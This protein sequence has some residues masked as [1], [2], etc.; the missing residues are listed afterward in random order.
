[1]KNLILCCLFIFLAG[2]PVSTVNASGLETM[3]FIENDESYFLFE[4]EQPI[5]GEIVDESS[6]ISIN[7]DT[8]TVTL[9]YEEKGEVTPPASIDVTRVVNGVTYQGTAYLKTYR[10]FDGVTTATYKGTLYR[11]ETTSTS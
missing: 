1:M 10:Y 4:S 11:V 9:T 8:M 3:A 7:G 6:Q 5:M 2:F